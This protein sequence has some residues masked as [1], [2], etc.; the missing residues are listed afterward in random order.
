M[1]FVTYKLAQVITN[2]ADRFPDREAVRF[3]SHSL[4]YT[5]LETRTN[6][7]ARTLIEQGISR[8]D[9][10]GIYM[11]KGLESAVSIYGIMKAGAA[12]VPIDPFAP[13]SRVAFV[14]QD[15]GI[16]HLI[17]KEGKLDQIAQVFSEGANPDHLIG[18]PPQP[19]LPVECITWEDVFNTPSHSVNLNLTELDLAYILYTSGSTG[20]PKGIMHTHRSGLSFP[21]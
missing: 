15:C 19:D 9:R 21:A 3:S 1:L 10:V 7:L 8:G 5:E 12:Y 17:T 4:T 2:S 18:V 20:T 6:S 11:N 16:R 14:I 13:V